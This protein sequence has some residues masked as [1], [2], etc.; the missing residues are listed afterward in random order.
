M[1]LKKLDWQLV[2]FACLVLI[3]A[4]IFGFQEGLTRRSRHRNP[5]ESSSFAIARAEAAE[6]VE[7]SHH[8]TMHG[9]A[10]RC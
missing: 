10:G 1:G 9:M 5:L 7:F 8:M 4:V 3:F 6:A 2:P